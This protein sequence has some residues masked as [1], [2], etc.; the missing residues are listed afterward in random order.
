MI[1]R[2]LGRL[3]GGGEDG[4][5]AVV[6]DGSVVE[7][8][9]VEVDVHGWGHCLLVGWFDVYLYLGVLKA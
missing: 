3:M 7:D 4:A 1:G 8:V 5:G 6:L 9:L 2:D